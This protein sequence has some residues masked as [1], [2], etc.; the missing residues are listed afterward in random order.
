MP[1]DG[2]P[3][4]VGVCGQIDGFRVF[5]HARQ[6]GQYLFA[7][8]RGN[9]L[10]LEVR[11]GHAHF[12]DWQIAHM[13]NRSRDLPAGAE[14]F[15]HLFHLAGGFKNKQLC[16]HDVSLLRPSCGAGLGHEARRGL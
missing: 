4:A 8:I 1:G 11:R 15:L 5:Y 10:W 3:F 13:A 14:D 2:F 6:P 16:A 9:I 7:P 12:F